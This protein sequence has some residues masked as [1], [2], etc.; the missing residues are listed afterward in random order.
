MC[1]AAFA[2][3]ELGFH[4]EVGPCNAWRCKLPMNLQ[5]GWS[6]RASAETFSQQHSNN[7]SVGVHPSMHGNEQYTCTAPL[8][9]LLL[10]ANATSG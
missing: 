2:A 5:I 8:W 9:A 6:L 3:V 4:A 1:P 7:E 10:L